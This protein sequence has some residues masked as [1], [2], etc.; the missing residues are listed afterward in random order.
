VGYDAARQIIVSVLMMLPDDGPLSPLFKS[1]IAQIP[2]VIRLDFDPGVVAI[3]SQPFWLSWHDGNRRRRHAP[4][5]FARLADGT[6]LVI[7]CRPQNRIAP[8]D[9]AAFAATAVPAG[10]SGAEAAVDAAGQ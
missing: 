3:A 5:Y 7:G 8:R 6:G 2:N 1:R 4:D 9:A 10:G